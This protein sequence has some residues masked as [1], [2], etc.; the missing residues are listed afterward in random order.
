MKTATRTAPFFYLAPLLTAPPV[1][2]LIGE[3]QSGPETLLGYAQR[4]LRLSFAPFP[5]QLTTNNSHEHA[6]HFDN[7]NGYLPLWWICR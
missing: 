5:T 6:I 1:R 2:K 3:W 4:K 7:G